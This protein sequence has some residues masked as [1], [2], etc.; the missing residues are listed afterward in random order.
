MG[1]F[2]WGPPGPQ[3]GPNQVTPNPT[4][5]Y[6]PPAWNPALAYI[7][8]AP[9]PVSY[10]TPAPA[11]H[12]GSGGGVYLH[13]H[14]PGPKHYWLA[15]LLSFLFGPVGL[16]YASKKG[17]LILLLLLV[18]VPVGLAALGA[19]PGAIHRHPLSVQEH[20][21]IMNRMWSA[22]VFFSMIWC[23]IGVRRYNQTLKA[24]K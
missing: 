3:S 1:S 23:V 18:G 2:P 9:T 13:T 10:G 17:A 8:P 15:V 7:P 5:A 22:C 11:A 12:T 19:W 20:D 14:T 4:P 6:V 24:A 16:F 21:S